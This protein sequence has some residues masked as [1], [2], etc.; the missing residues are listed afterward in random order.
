[1]RIR[2]LIMLIKNSPAINFQKIAFFFYCHICVNSI[3]WS[4]HAFFVLCL[5]ARKQLAGLEWVCCLLQLVNRICCCVPRNKCERCFI[6]RAYFKHPELLINLGIAYASLSF[7]SECLD[8]QPGRW[9]AWRPLCD[10][11]E[12][13]C[14]RSCHV[15]DYGP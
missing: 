14:Q 7:L 8:A 1:M 2:I 4:D 5:S 10:E 11:S 12:W 3:I 13:T 9:E 15:F 6:F